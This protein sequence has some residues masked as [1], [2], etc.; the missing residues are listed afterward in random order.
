MRWTTVVA[1]VAL[2][3]AALW[4]DEGKVRA[5]KFN[6]ND[7]GNVPTGW[8]AEKTGAGEG[9]VWTVVEDETA[10]SKSGYVLAQ[11]AESPNGL[12]NICVA[13]D[14][15]YKDVEL[16]VSFKPIAGK[17]DQGGGFVWRYQDHNNYYLARLNP[18]GSASSYAVYKV[19]NGKRSQFQGKRLPKVPVGEWHQLTVKMKGDEIECYFDGKK[20]LEAKDSTFKDSGKVG[21]WSKS[22]ARTHFDDFKVSGQ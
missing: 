11:T 2:S 22:D 15:S 6:K 4:A 1:L 9:S 5:L 10:P 19:E 7:V 8:K 14:T 16:S 17:N 3:G 21:L 13:Q 20:V 18:V 12:F